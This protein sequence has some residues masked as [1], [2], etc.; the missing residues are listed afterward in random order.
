MSAAG[1]ETRTEANL[2]KSL[3][4]NISKIIKIKNQIYILNFKINN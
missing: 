1:V 4:N 3:G 2:R